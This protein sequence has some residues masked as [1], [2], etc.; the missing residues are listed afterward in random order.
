MQDFITAL[1]GQVTVANLW[2][3]IAPAAALV[4]VAVLISFAYYVLSK[5]VRGV[6]K[7]K[8]KI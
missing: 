3:S 4:G 5:V 2:A 6:G 7:G 1:L 8:A